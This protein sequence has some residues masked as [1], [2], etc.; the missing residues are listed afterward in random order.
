MD[1]L[2]EGF[3]MSFGDHRI[4]DGGRLGEGPEIS[5]TTLGGV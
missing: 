1:R 2:Q 5:E 3:F 4:R